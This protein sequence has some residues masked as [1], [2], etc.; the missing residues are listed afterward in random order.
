M[1]FSVNPKQDHIDGAIWNNE[2]A[3]CCPGCG[4]EAVP[5]NPMERQGLWTHVA[6]PASCKEDDE[7]P[8]MCYFVEFALLYEDRTWDTEIVEMPTKYSH[9]DCTDEERI[10]WAHA[11]LG[12][13]V[14]YRKVVQFAIYNSEPY[15]GW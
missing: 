2:H 8:S 11:V 13:R 12:N 14:K 5:V 9:E 10:A 3:G 6:K 4:H 7:F 15:N 1:S